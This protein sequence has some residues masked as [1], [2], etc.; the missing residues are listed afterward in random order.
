[1]NIGERLLLKLDDKGEAVA[2]EIDREPI[3]TWEDLIEHSLLGALAM[4]CYAD[5]ITARSTRHL[6]RQCQHYPQLL[7][8]S[9]CTS[10]ALV[11]GSSSCRSR[12]RRRGLRSLRIRGFSLWGFSF[13]GFSL[14]GFR[15]GLT[16]VGLIFST[17]LARRVRRRSTAA[18]LERNT[19]L[20]K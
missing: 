3:S 7:L 20:C 2:I 16:C 10:V 18:A 11:G 8:A 13:R 5:G 15:L 4:L 19:V 14:G 17:C 1:M 12:N 9:T 6:I